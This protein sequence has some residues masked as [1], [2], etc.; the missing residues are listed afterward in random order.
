MGNP[1]ENVLGL[2]FGNVPWNF[3]TSHIK[4]HHQTNGS[5]GDTFYLWDFDR[6]DFC[7]FMLY[8]HRILLH[9]L[10]VTSIR[11]FR[12]NNRQDKASQLTSGLTTYLT[13]AVAVFAMTR[14]LSF[15]FFVYIQPMLCMTYFLALI[16]IG[17]HG[18]LEFDEQGNHVSL[19]DSTTIV[20]GTDDVFG[21]DDHMAHH[22]NTGVYFKDL[23]AH[24]QAKVEEFKR[25]KASVF[26]TLSIAEL[27]IFI[28][29]GI[30]DK[31]AEH[32][33]DYTG[34]MSKAEII[35][36]LQARAKRTEITYEQYEEYYKNPTLEARKALRAF[37]VT[38]NVPT[39]ISGNA[40]NHNKDTD[41]NSINANNTAM[42]NNVNNSSAPVLTPAP[43][44]R[45]Q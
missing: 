9:M 18:F 17:F 13:V 25:H 42:S 23:P 1:F 32:Y 19:V 38:V 34:S 35:S 40:M 37:A 16:N 41:D 2:F 27:S 21:E 39:D 28:L 36:M 11:Y 26:H 29:L 15:L 14:S 44:E 7:G 10:G 4:I 12:A 20:H 6:T 45:A 24:Q 3:T 5:V 30:W 8:V 31:L 22:Y 33:V 43:V